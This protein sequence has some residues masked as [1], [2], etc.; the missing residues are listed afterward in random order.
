MIARPPNPSDG[1]GSVIAIWGCRAQSTSFKAIAR[2][3]T[4]AE[5]YLVLLGI[6]SRGVKK[7]AVIYEE[8]DGV[9]LSEVAS[10][11]G[12]RSRVD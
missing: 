7:N 9:V 11:L 5:R 2:A 10:E 1:K 12:L 3:A 8:R 6:T 4:G